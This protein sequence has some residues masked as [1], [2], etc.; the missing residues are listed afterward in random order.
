MELKMKDEH[1]VSVPEPALI[2]D[3][4]DN[5]TSVTVVKKPNLKIHM[6]RQNSE[7][8]TDPEW[9]KLSE[10]SKEITYVLRREGLFEIRKNA[11]GAFVSQREK[12]TNNLPGFPKEAT[13]E[14][15][16]LNF[17]KIPYELFEEVL[18]FFKAICDESK[19]EVYVQT[20]WDPAAGIYFNY[21]PKQVVS[22]A[23][24][25]YDR[26]QDLEKRCIL[27]LETHSHN[28]MN[29][30]FSG[31]DNADEKADRFFGVIGELNK[32]SPAMLYSY[33]CGGKRV[34][35]DM[36]GL[37]QSS[38]TKDFS[39]WKSRVTRNIAS[40]YVSHYSGG[41]A[42]YKPPGNM[43]R[44]SWD[45]STEDDSHES[46]SQTA[47]WRSERPGTKP[48]AEREKEAAEGVKQAAK[49]I[50]AAF[51][52]DEKDLGDV[53]PY[54]RRT[55]ETC[56]ISDAA[57]DENFTQVIEEI[58]LM[59]KNRG[60]TMGNVEKEAAFGRLLENLNDETAEL[61]AKTM[62]DF[63]YAQAMLSALDIDLVMND[64]IAEVE[65]EVEV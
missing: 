15:F 45:G 23:S 16:M 9:P 42:G 36:S 56:D 61:L 65:S 2:S 43:Q 34:Q 12:F 31:T 53:N 22:G 3:K 18:S 57:Y 28:T 35:I 46:G 44:H 63:G 37:F 24:V 11:V 4:E 5:A 51:D 32:S 26:D 39:D 17:G 7:F 49:E 1:T 10:L 55:K 54:F 47:L 64:D 30:F 48:F 40:A 14:G 13:S 29:A 52:K 19:D 33:V 60:A 58:T 50:R 8:Y 6:E 59:F 27:V 20:F 41:Y 21:V 38:P 62:F 25:R